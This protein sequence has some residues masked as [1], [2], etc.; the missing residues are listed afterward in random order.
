LQTTLWNFK[1]VK[2]GQIVTGYK[3]GFVRL[4][5]I[6]PWWQFCQESGSLCLP[7]CKQTSLTVQATETK[8]KFFELSIARRVRWCI[9]FVNLKLPLLIAGPINP[10]KYFPVACIIHFS[11]CMLVRTMWVLVERVIISFLITVA[12]SLLSTTPV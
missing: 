4:G 7:N 9:V 8:K 11:I 1:H 12:I 5:H 2:V 6:Y 3:T 10:Y